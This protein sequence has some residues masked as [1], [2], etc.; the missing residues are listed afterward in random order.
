MAHKANTRDRQPPLFRAKCSTLAQDNPFS[1]ISRS[2]DLLHVSFGLPRLRLPAFGV[3]LNAIFGIASDGTLIT[4][5]IQVHLLRLISVIK[6]SYIPATYFQLAFRLEEVHPLHVSALSGLAA[7]LH[8][9]SY[10]PRFIPKAIIVFFSSVGF[11]S[12]NTFYVT[13]LPTPCTTLLLSHP[14]LGPA[15]AELDNVFGH[16]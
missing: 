6:C 2:H 7:I 16:R 14:G 5:P 4:C 10:L 9:S 13:G 8:K 15:M 1:F 3:H 12:G 11:C